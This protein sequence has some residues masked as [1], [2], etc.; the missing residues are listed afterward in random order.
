M[1]KKVSDKIESNISISYDDFI[2]FFFQA[3]D[4][5]RD[6]TVT[7]VQTCALPILRLS[8]SDPE[9]AA[10]AASSA[11][12][13]GSSPERPPGCGPLHAVPTDGRGD[14]SSD[15]FS[16]SGKP[17]RFGSA[18]YRV[19]RVALGCRRSDWCATDNGHRATRLV[20]TSFGPDETRGSGA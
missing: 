3:E 15:P 17:L 19:S 10:P 20:E 8:A 12:P 14:E 5:I 6:L 1:T 7:G 4:G 16:G 18:A 2:F 11:L 13:S 9:R